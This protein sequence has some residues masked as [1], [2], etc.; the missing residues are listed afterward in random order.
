MQ[1][2]RNQSELQGVRDSLVTLRFDLRRL[3]EEAKQLQEDVV[4][5]KLTVRLMREL[6]A[7]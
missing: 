1:S 3:Q 7:K 5:V 4:E 6:A 2:L